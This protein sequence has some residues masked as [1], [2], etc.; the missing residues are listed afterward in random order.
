M[1]E[2]KKKHWTPKSKFKPGGEKGKLHRE[3]GVPEGEKARG[4]IWMLWCVGA[5]L[6]LSSPYTGDREA[7][8]GP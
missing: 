3:M 7:R 1:A 4:L 6:S 5:M 8:L 2:D